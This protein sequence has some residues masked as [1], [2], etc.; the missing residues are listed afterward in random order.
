[1][2]KFDRNRTKDGWQK[3]C[4][5]K[6][7]DRH[8]E[9][10][11]HLAVNQKWMMF[12]CIL[13]HTL[14]L[15][16]HI[17]AASFGDGSF[18]VAAHKICLEISPSSISSN[19]YQTRYSWSSSQNSL[20]PAGLPVPLAPSSLRPI[21]SSITHLQNTLQQISSWMTRPTNLPTLN[22]SKTVFLLIELKKQLDRRRTTPHITP[23]TLLVTLPSSLMNFLPS[24]TKFQPS[25][26]LAVT[27]LDSF[28]VSLLTLTSPQLTLHHCHLH[29]SLQTRLL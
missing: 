24:L 22:S 3:L 25:P 13:T 11:D 1:M 20:F 7:T 9:N 27:I 8:Y 5:N 28:V 6:Q 19:V 2:S 17:S 15:M 23:L 4:T 29:R 21:D 12:L 26:K 14:L 16:M 18:S 10:N